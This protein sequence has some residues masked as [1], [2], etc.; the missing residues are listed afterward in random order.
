MGTIFTLKSKISLK[1]QSL[2]TVNVKQRPLVE[3]VVVMSEKK[4]YKSPL[5]TQQAKMKRSNPCYK[6]FVRAIL[7]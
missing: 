1:T 6:T 3:F 2:N 4:R 5:D 7:S